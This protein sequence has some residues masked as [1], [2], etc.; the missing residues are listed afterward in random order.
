MT[1]STLRLERIAPCDVDR[2]LVEVGA[3][4]LIRT[5]AGISLEV[6]ADVVA[7]AVAML[8][9]AGLRSI[10]VDGAG[11]VTRGLVA[12]VAMHLEPLSARGVVDV[13]TIRTL[14][15]GEATAR[16]ARRGAFRRAA[17]RDALRAVLADAE[18]A[19]VWRRVLYGSPKAIRAL[20]GVRPVVFDRGALE[21]GEERLALVGTAALTRWIA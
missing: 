1:T 14:G 18:R 3:L 15:D 20:R 17:D 11:T 10:A 5:D 4:R 6:A 19:F 16:L 7:R 13:V 21:R 12:G 8:A 9:R 2:H